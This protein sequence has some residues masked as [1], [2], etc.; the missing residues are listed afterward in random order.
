MPIVKAVLGPVV[1]FVGYV[2]LGVVIGLVETAIVDAMTQP[3]PDDETAKGPII[4]LDPSEYR[5]VDR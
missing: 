1:S 2:A 3:M 4:D 5:Y